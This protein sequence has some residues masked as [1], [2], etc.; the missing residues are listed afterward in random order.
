[1][2]IKAKLLALSVVSML[3]VLTSIYAANGQVSSGTVVSVNP[4]QNSVNV[5]DTFALNITLSDV[6]NLYALDVTL[7]YNNSVLQLEN[8]NPDLGTSSGGVLYGD[9]VTNDANSIA[10]GCVYYNTSLSTADEFQLF[11]TSVAPANSFN[12]SGTIVT[13]TFDAIA[14]G[15]S[16]LVLNCSLADHPAPGETTSNFIPNSD[17]NGSVDVGQIPEFSQV[18]VLFILAIVV[19]AVALVLA[20]KVSV[21]NRL[22]SMID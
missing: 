19:A 2:S 12:G 14:N 7:D 22:A 5:G 13:L 11:A 21:K 3:L 18:A 9:P 17:L 8:E 1:M 4:A 15:H 16:D 20:K 6:Q 10:A